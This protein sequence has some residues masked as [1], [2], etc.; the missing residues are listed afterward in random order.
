MKGLS[1]RACVY[2]YMYGCMRVCIY[3]WDACLYV[4]GLP[5]M[6]FCG[7]EIYCTCFATKK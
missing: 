7:A 6:V 5:D 4:A 1:R 2:V 3:V